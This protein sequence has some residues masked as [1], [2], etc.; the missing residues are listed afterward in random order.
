MS[1]TVRLLALV[2]S[3]GRILA[4]HLE[5]QLI[6]KE[7]DTP[8]AGFVPLEGQQL[9]SIDVPQE[10]LELPGPDLHRFFSQV[11]INWPAAIEVPKVGIVRKHKG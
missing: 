5:D 7:G 8:S 3:A 10:A 2:D 9:I 4:A 1:T 11:R 6:S